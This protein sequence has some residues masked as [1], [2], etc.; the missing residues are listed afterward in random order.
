MKYSGPFQGEKEAVM[1]HILMEYSEPVAGKTNIKDLLS[2][3]HTAVRKSGL[4]EP[5]AIKSRAVSYPLWQ[6]GDLRDE[7][8]FIHVTLMILNKRSIQQRRELGQPVLELLKR[9][10]TGVHSLTVEVREMEKETYLK[11][12]YP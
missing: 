11:Y 12:R 5:E 7:G 3:I 9:S 8:H 10:V 2:E 1:P 4:F 6:V